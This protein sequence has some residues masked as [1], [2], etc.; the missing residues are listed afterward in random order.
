VISGAATSKVLLVGKGPSAR[1][2]LESLAESFTVAGVIRNVR[3]RGGQED[4]VQRC[5]R[6]LGVPVLTDTSVSGLE[7]ALA[8]CR[9]DCTVISSYDRILDPSLLDRSRFVNVHYSMLPRYR[10]LAAVQWGIVNGE[11]EQGIT[12]H[13]ITPGLDAGNILF[14]EKVEVGPHQTAAD[15]YGELNGIQRRILGETIA[16]HLD[17]YTGVPQ[18]ASAA[19]YACGRMPEDSEIDWSDPTHRIYGQIRAFHGSLSI[20]YPHAYSY[21]GTCRIS[22]TKA[23]PAEDAPPYAGRVPGRVVGRS[24]SDGHVDVLTG[25]GVL[26]IHEV[27]TGDGVVRPASAA[28]RSTKHTLGLRAEELLERIEALSRQVDELRTRP[29]PALQPDGT[30]RLAERG[31]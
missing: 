14:Q 6:D 24:S 28:I 16:R 31:R 30:R 17:G 22:I 8:E 25:D 5:A 26:R 11:P 7:R 27:M 3:Q 9:P 21:L 15:I 12:V 23:A 10:G 18:D 13:V 20:P 4:E 29:H 1:T 19:T 2:A